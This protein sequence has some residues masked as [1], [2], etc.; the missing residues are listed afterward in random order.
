M[1]EGKEKAEGG[2]NV[3]RQGERENGHPHRYT[4]V[5]GNT[6]ILTFVPLFLFVPIL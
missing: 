2:R 3:E 6:D 4:V 5:T 1:K